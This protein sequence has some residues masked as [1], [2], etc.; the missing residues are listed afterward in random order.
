MAAGVHGSEV[1]PV[2]SAADATLKSSAGY[3]HWISAANS[4]ASET[5]FIEL[6]D[7]T[8]DLGTDRWAIALGDIAAGGSVVHAVFD[9]PIEFTAGITIDI[10]T[11]TVVATVGIT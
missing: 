6:N 2:V 4:H 3:V 5:A 11:G 1:R 8:D 9:P 7:S 10:T